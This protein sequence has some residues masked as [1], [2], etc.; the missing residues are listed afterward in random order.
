LQAIKDKNYHLKIAAYKNSSPP[1]VNIDWTLDCLLNIYDYSINF[2]NDNYKTYFDQ[3]K[4]FNPDLIISDMEPYTSNIANTLNIT[5][6]QCSSSLINYALD[7]KDKKNIGLY[8][9]YTFLSEEVIHIPLIDNLNDNANCNLVYSHLGD[10]IIPPTLKDNFQWVRPYHFDGK[11]H[12]TCQ[13]NIVSATMQNNKNIF[14]LLSRHPDSVIFTSFTDQFY[15][16]FQL[17]N[18]ADHQEYACNLK[19]CKLFLCDGTTSFLAD[20]FYA[21]KYCIVSPNYNNL[22]CMVNSLFSEKFGL[23]HNIYNI[24]A[25]I[26]SELSR[27][28]ANNYN[29]NIKYLHEHI[30]NI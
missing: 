6:W 20:A 3:V 25:D 1:N 29:K 10:M 28:V 8:K 12:F 14:A 22:E 17:K 23:S 13:H 30:D 16:N 5:L 21:G 2:R 26:T 4:S 11:E 15:K 18:V 24:G 27:V 9:K 7:G 19:N